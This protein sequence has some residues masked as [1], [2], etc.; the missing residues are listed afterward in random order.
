MPNIAPLEYESLIT[1]L[2]KRNINAHKGDFGH[3][4][5]IGGDYGY[6]GAPVLAA[7]GALRVGAGLV[8]LASHKD[9]LNGIN[10]S[11]PEI[12]CHA[13]DQV[14]DLQ[15]LLAKVTILVVGPGLCRTKWSAEIY[16]MIATTKLPLVLDAD[17]LYYLAQKPLRNIN[18]VLTPHAG[19][20]ATLLN[21]TSAI[22]ESQRENAIKQ[23]VEKYESTV[24]LKG[25]GTLVASP[26]QMLGICHAGNPGMAS[27]G[28]GDLLSGVIGGLIAQGLD[29]DTA[30]KLGVSIH[31]KA[32]DI[33]AQDGQRGVI[34]TDLLLPIKQLME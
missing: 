33:A 2:P 34:A 31:A 11:H 15:E 13:I 28:M 29:L 6:P 25:A 5:V 24:V 20:A 22:S 8:S 17:G 23:L 1:R 18:R 30:A 19:E 21:Q 26:H 12:M 3:V 10:A 4:L 32:G 9:N 7:L 14:A 16:A 27:G